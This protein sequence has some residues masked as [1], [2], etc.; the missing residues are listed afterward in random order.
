M[1]RT[2]L[3][4]ILALS[5]AGCASEV[6]KC[7]DAWEDAFSSI[8]DDDVARFCEGACST[9]NE[10]KMTK[11]AARANTRMKCLRASQGQ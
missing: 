2:G 3:L 5:T 4:L 7:V 9:Y 1:K 6:D 11:A 8:P 10:P